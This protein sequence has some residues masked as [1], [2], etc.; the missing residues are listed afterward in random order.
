MGE[1]TC[2][3]FLGPAPGFPVLLGF[4]SNLSSSEV[5]LAYGEELYIRVAQPLGCFPYFN[6]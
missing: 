2:Y 6:L 3:D 4:L 1:V 5:I